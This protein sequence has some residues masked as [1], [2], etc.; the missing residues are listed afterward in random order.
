MRVWL[1]DHTVIY[2][3]ELHIIQKLQYFLKF[4][5]LSPHLVP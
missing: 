2:C 5:S 1:S 4:W 3:F